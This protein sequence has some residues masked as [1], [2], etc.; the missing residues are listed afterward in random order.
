MAPRRDLHAGLAP[1]RKDPNRLLFPAYVAALIACAALLLAA[2]VWAGRNRGG[3]GQARNEIVFTGWGDTVERRVFEDVIA[4]FERLNPGAKVRYIQIPQNY[5]QKLQ[6]MMAG[7]TPPDV[8]YIAD[9]DFPGFVTRG[10][11]VPL[12]DYIRRSRVVR[13]EDFWPSGYKRFRYDGRRLGEGTQYAIPKGIG[14]LAMFYNKELFRKA[15]VPYPSPSRPWTWNEALAAWKKLTIRDPKRPDL[16]HQ[17]GVANFPGEDAVWSNGGE[18]V[19]PDG[20]R[21]VAPDDPLTIE[22]LQWTAD[23]ANVHRVSPRPSEAQSYQPGPMFDTGRLACLIAGKWNIPHYRELPFDWDVA[24]VPVSPRTRKQVGWSGAVGL[25][26]GRTCRNRDLAWRFIEFAA[27]PRGQVI[28]LRS[29]FDMP[30]QRHLAYTR[31]FRQPG[32]RPAH[33]EVFIPIAQ[34]ARPGLAPVAPTTEWLDEYHQRMRPMWAGE[35]SMRD[36]LRRIRPFVQAGLDRAW[37]DR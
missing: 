6:I 30:N 21:F 31:A 5:M 13:L 18:I 26:I 29:G 2:M 32:K 33:P 27:G 9:G 36:G 35:E 7:G 3:W 23:L 17:F 10:M 34:T 11:M 16:V 37:N 22:A 1:C 28:Q 19:S 8:F 20:R 14:P 24:P 25:A 15:G 4:E 12:D